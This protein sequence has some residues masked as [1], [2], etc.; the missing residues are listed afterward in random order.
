MKILLTIS[1]RRILA[2]D[3]TEKAKHLAADLRNATTKNDRRRLRRLVR[4][5]THWREIWIHRAL[6]EKEMA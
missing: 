4:I 3:S 2:A 1:Q 6:I 5:H